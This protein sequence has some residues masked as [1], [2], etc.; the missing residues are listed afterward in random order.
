MTIDHPVLYAQGASDSPDHGIGRVRYAQGAG[1]VL[2]TLRKVTGGMGN[3]VTECY[4][5]D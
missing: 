1:R 2:Q 3:K 4:E 5:L